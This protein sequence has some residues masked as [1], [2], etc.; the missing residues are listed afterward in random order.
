MSA[1]AL[2]LAPGPFRDEG[3]LLLY[4][5]HDGSDVAHDTAW[6]F[7]EIAKRPHQRLLIDVRG[8]VALKQGFRAVVYKRHH[9]LDGRRIAVVGSSRLQEFLVSFLLA[10]TGHANARFFHEEPTARAWLREEPHG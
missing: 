8:S 6:F 1:P 9:E 3:D 10:A 5:A 4:V 7:D 2:A